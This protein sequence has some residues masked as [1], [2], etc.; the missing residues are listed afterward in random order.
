MKIAFVFKLRKHSRVNLG[1]LGHILP[2]TKFSNVPIMIICKLKPT[3]LISTVAIEA[4]KPFRKN[5]YDVIVTV[6]M[7]GT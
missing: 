1:K 4:L 5:L 7:S 6:T 3:A 2:V